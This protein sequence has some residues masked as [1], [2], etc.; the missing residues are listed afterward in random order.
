MFFVRI[1]RNIRVIVEN[2]AFSPYLYVK[3]VQNKNLKIM[4]L[5][6]KCK[7][8]CTLRRSHLFFRFKKKLK[9]ILFNIFTHKPGICEYISSLP[10]TNIARGGGE[11]SQSTKTPNLSFPVDDRF[12]GP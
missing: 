8:D 11:I 6:N 10:I 1:I 5:A 7:Q 9:C 4:I 12:V 2:N 3:N